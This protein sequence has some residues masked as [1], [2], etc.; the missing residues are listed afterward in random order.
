MLNG[1][2]SEDK[3]L[4][5]KSPNLLKKMLKKIEIKMNRKKNSVSSNN[6]KCSCSN[7]SHLEN[8]NL[9]SVSSQ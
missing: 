3:N 2:S 8:L 9:S 5:Q 7:S 4:F 1:L 6:S